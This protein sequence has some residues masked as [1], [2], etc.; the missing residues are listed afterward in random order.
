MTA[1]LTRLFA[2]AVSQTMDHLL[3]AFLQSPALPPE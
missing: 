2:A 1:V 3:S